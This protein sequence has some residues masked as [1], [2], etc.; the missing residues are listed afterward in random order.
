MK[1]GV[2]LL[3]ELYDQAKDE[4]A[5][6]DYLYYIAVADA[7]LKNYDDALKLLDGILHVQPGNRQVIELRKETEKRMRNDG[8]IGM[9]V[10]GGIAA[11]AIG[12]I[13]GLGIA[14]SKGGRH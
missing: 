9:A 4:Q 11:A 14:L 7:K 5:K 3:R 2:K 1:L 10:V 8:L 6:R 12:G 13:V